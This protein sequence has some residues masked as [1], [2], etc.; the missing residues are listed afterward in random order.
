MKFKTLEI[1]HFLAI[2]DGKV[3]L[4]DRGLV[5]I[6]GVNMDDTSAESNGAGKSSLADALC[7]CL[8][9]VTAR[10]VTGDDVIND[11]AAKGTRVM[12]EVEDGDILYRIARHRKHKPHK[13]ALRVEQVNADGSVVDFTKGTDKLTQVVVDKIVGASLEVFRSA[14]YAGQELMPDLPGM[15]DKQLKILI[16]EA[17]GVTLL[18]EAYKRA[19]AKV[20]TVKDHVSTLQVTA[21]RTI[22]RRDMI[23]SQIETGKASIKS[24]KAAQKVKVS[25]AAAEVRALIVKAKETKDAMSGKPTVAMLNESIAEIDAQIEAV[26]HEKAELE[27]HG[28]I[29]AQAQR[30][31]T[32]K[33]TVLNSLKTVAQALKTERDEID[34]KIGCACGECGREITAA[35]IGAAREAVHTKLLD[36]AREIKKASNELEVL[37][38]EL[39]T[40][41]DAREAFRASM[42]DVSAASAQR[43]SLT[44]QRHEIEAALAQQQR[45]VDLA[46][47][48]AAQ[49][50][51]LEAET[52]PYSAQVEEGKKLLVTIEEGIAASA[53]LVEAAGVDLLHAEAVVRVF[54]PAGVRAHILDEVTPYLNDRTAHY[55]STLS[56]GN[57]EAT[58]NTLSLTSKGE[59]TEKF[60]IEVKND[61][62][63]QSFAGLSGGEKRKVRLSTALALQDLVATRA[64][65]QIDLFIGDEIDH[66]LDEPGLE[67]LTQI[68]EEKAR[69]RGSVFVISHSDLSD[70]ISQMIV[71]K[72][73]GKQS[74][75]EEMTA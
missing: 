6:Q 50:K 5:L 53:A 73:E 48:K 59:Y 3:S 38:N 33:Q 70:W 61:K 26:E 13:N 41:T 4:A 8:Y 40:L 24:W 56:D 9:G 37:Q 32:S 23:A 42:T 69:E 31:V 55:L 57:I 54:S 27:E 11:T 68:L 1:E 20:A 45:Y 18:E 19:R 14:V 17:A 22:D 74:T 7:W 64:M 65:K 21:Q 15:T 30:A 25:D 28:A 39:Q 66:A 34:H 71:V 44:R 63:A 51:R 43:A 12:V 2:K 10:G 29:V 49:A 35:E 75:I 72:K 16:E 67:R 46:R 47:E 62:G 52:D 60:S 36:K 58:W